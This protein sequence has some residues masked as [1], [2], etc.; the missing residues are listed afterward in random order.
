[1]T[2]E[3]MRQILEALKQWN[4]PLYKRGAVIK[5]LEKAIAKAE[6]QKPVGRF[7]RFTDG[8]WRE[9]TDGSPGQLLYTLPQP[10]QE[11]GKPVAWMQ[12]GQPELY[13]KEEKDEKRGYVIPLYTHPQPVTT[14]S[15]CGES[16][17]EDGYL[18]T[19]CLKCVEVVSG[20]Q[21]DCADSS[22]CWEPCGELGKSGAHAEVFDF[23]QT[24]KPNDGVK[25]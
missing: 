22:Q 6:K 13:V 16:S 8:I 21:C 19:Y 18:A 20:K 12:E 10:K 17:T 5:L 9:V 4:T 11:Q 3:E 1:M 7:A 23:Q 14:C 2:L 15:G 25:T 24:L